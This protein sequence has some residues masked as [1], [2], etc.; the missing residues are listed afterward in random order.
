MFIH[1]DTDDTGATLGGRISTPGKEP[2]SQIQRLV[3]RLSIGLN[4][5]LKPDKR[6]KEA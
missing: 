4:E 1:I 6:E 3:D 2:E 5:A